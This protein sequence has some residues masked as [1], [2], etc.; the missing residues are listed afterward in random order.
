ME[1]EST[2]PNRI[3]TNIADEMRQSY[4]DYAMSVIIGRAL[5]DVRDGLKPANRR[6]LYGMQQMGLQ[7][8]RPYRKSAKIVGEVMGNYHP[9]G[10]Q[11][12][13]DTLV[14]MAQPFNMRAT[15]IDGQGNFGSVD[16]DPPAAQRYTEAR[17]TRLGASMMEDIDRDTVDFQPTYDDSALE[18][19]VLPTVLPNLLVNGAS[20]IAVGMAT[21]IPPHNLQEVVDGLDFLLENQDLTPDER[22]EGLIERI[23]GPDFPTGGFILGREGIR[24]AYR[25]GRGTLV[26]RAR[27]EIELR[28]G[29]RE[30]IVVTEIPYQVNKARLIEKI[31]ELARDD[32]VRGIVD[33]RDES[34]RQGMRVVVD[35]KR[36]EP[37]QVVLNNLYKHTPLQDSFGVIFLAIVDLRPRVL[38]LL[39]A[40]ELFLD[41]R[42]DVVR[43]RTAFELRKAEARAHVLEGYVVALDHLDEVI[44]LIRSSRTPEEAKVDL[45]SRFDL[46]EIQADEILK[47]QLQRLTGL[48]RQ[49]IVDELATLRERI[50]DLRAILASPRRID[51]I[52]KDELAELRKVHGEVRR[53]EIVEAAN[54]IEIE[55][56]I[57]DEDVAISITHSGYVKRTSLT[58]YRAQKRGGRGTVGMRTR[59]ED[60]VTDLFIAST[61]SY[62]LIFTDRGRVYWLKVHAIPEV[63]RQGKGKA[64]VNLVSLQAGEKIAAFC[65]VRDFSSGGHVLLAT[66]RGII[67]KTKLE[68]FSN[69]RPSGIIG[70]SIE[71]GDTLIGAAVTSGE[72][73]LLIGTERGQA[74]HFRETDVRPM[75]RTAYGV[76]GIVLGQRD[77][78][79]S[80]GVVRPGGTV[81]TVT[82]RGFGKR[83]PIEDYRLQA[84]GGR[85]II[86]IKTSERNGPVVGVNFLRREEQVMLITEKGMIIRL[87]TADI[88]IIGRNTQ[89]VRLIQL[90]EGDHLVSVAR[91]AERE[92]DDESP[93]G[94]PPTSGTPE[95]SKEDP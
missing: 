91:L 89:G 17:L 22:L 47:L 64:V 49:K 92:D 60:F 23:P 57:A 54:A 5:P 45:V 25:T 72:D 6:V 86:N 95:A 70:L 69:P 75:G 56:L 13:Y 63:P 2:P 67:K 68:A 79:V 94:P 19:A 65:A 3:P 81:L 9:H 29:G 7:P 87:N 78:A 21:N 59:D 15:L 71:E 40:C 52:I 28:K 76:K 35:V 84:R 31:A 82:R 43:R 18:P 26:M 88:R 51:G 41:F 10:D 37:A 12:I 61:H 30:S 62:I 55:D 42:R 77:A 44:A 53:T 83:T 93:G 36:G 11:A 20:G 34:G 24:R 58:S 39:D 46:T 8:G 74:I 73:E 4:M 14:R 85:G 90:E 80:L 33:V 38:S 50:A 32:R 1:P 48:E 16:G 66:R 27:A